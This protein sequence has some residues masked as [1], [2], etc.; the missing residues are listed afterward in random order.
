M[1]LSTPGLVLHTTNYSETSVIAKVFTRLLGVKSYIIKGVRS[2]RNRAKMNLLQPLS[3]LDMVVYNNPKTNMNYTKEMH[4]AQAFNNIATDSIRTSLVFFLDELL[5]KSLHEEEPNPELFD[6]IVDCLSHIDSE[7]QLSG[8]LPIAY[9]LNVAR[10][11]GI[12][13]LDNHSH[14]EPLF[15]LKEGRFLAPPSSY[16]LQTDANV[17]YFL[18]ADTSSLLHHY[19]EA[20]HTHRPYPPIPLSRRTHLT[21]I[22]LYYYQVHLSDFH[23]FTSHQVLHSVLG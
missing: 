19:L 12:E 8:S 18:D 5:Y 22:L 23:N 10:L 21:N 16:A 17:D 1:I 7:P 2:G 14:H 11:I 20:T 13:P 9:L 15:N 4:P 6:Y 3:Y